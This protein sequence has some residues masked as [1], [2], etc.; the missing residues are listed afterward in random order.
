MQVADGGDGS[1]GRDMGWP[2]LVITLAE[3]PQCVQGLV[4]TGLS[5]AVRPVRVKAPLWEML[6]WVNGEGGQLAVQ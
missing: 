4:G 6:T 1:R 2:A 3:G 5:Y